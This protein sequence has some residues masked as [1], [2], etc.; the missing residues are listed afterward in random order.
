MLCEVCCLL[1]V[2][3]WVGFVEKIYCVFCLVECL[4]YDC[5]CV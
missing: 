3:Y 5:E 1:C 4:V 2:V